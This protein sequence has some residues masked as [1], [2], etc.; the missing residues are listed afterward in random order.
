VG[1]KKKP[2]TKKKSKKADDEPSFL[3]G[4]ISA[5][6]KV[7]PK[8]RQASIVRLDDDGATLPEVT[9][10]IP[11]GIP[12]L[13]QALGGGWAIGR[14]S[15]V[16][17]P[18]GCGKTAL[19][20]LA[21]KGV[22]IIG[23]NG[24]AYDYEHAFDTRVFTQLG[25]DKK[26]LLILRPATAEEGWEMLW[27]LLDKAKAKD[28]SPVL[29]GWDSIALTPTVDELK[30]SGSYGPLAKVMTECSKRLFYEI[31]QC[32]AH[33]MFL[34]QERTKMGGNTKFVTRK[35]VGGDWID[36]A[37]TQRVRCTRYALP[38]SGQPKLGY[39]VNL[40][41]DKNRLVPPHQSAQYAL[42][43]YYGPSIEMTIYWILVKEKKITSVG[44]GKYRMS[45]HKATFKRSQWHAVFNLPKME[46]FRRVAWGHYNELMNA[47]KPKIP[48][49][50]EG[51]VIEDT[52]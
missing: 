30:G 43:F 44:G 12:W 52:V 27:A 6:R 8:E 18:P 1:A 47:A 21:L 9:E 26:R 29:L 39:M 2:T 32:R 7:V 38:E 37:T 3:D 23:G 17:G 15:E 28:A 46:N 34:N 41:T 42:D 33:V 51:A 49:L 16:Y 48:G 14:A 50:A 31:A 35:T 22:Q 24:V 11:S 36:Y 10:Y 5:I 4:V 25:Y 45:G 13:D 20:D 19:M 40:K